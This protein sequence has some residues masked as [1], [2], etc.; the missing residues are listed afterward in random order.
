[1]LLYLKICNHLTSAFLL[2]ATVLGMWKGYRQNATDFYL[3]DIEWHASID[4]PSENF[5]ANGLF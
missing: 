5:A 3:E 4:V 2:L 1:M